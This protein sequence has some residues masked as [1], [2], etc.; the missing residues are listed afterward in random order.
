MNPFSP[1]FYLD[2]KAMAYFLMGRDQDA[3]RSWAQVSEP[4]PDCMA[5]EVAAYAFLGDEEAARAKVEAFLHEFS[6]V[7]AGDP[8][9]GP[10]DYVRW[11]TQVSNPFAREEDRGR[12]VEG[13]RRAGLST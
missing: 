3:L 5:W 2:G 13:L 1:D 9:A 10:G 4:I 12:L 8:A 6:A 11:I 7:W